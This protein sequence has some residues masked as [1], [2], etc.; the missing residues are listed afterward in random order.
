MENKV[1]KMEKMKDYL[2][3]NNPSILVRSPKKAQ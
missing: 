1:I 2:L 3:F